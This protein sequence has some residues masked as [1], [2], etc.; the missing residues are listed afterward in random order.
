MKRAEIYRKL[1]KEILGKDLYDDCYSFFRECFTRK[2]MYKIILTRRCFSLFKIFS[3]ILKADGIENEYGMIITDNAVSL[4]M[5]EIR[6][7]LGDKNE[8]GYG[9]ASVLIID[10]IIIYGRTINELLNRIFDSVNTDSFFR[11]RVICMVKNTG[12]IIDEKYKDLI[13]SRYGASSVGWK[14]YSYKFSKLIKAADI[15][16]TSYIVSYRGSLENISGNFAE[17][18]FQK[19]YFIKNNE[20]NDLKVK[21][22][23]LCVSLK[24]GNFCGLVRVYI[25]NKI[26]SFLIAPLIILNE[27]D[28]QAADEISRQV[29]KLYCDDA[30]KT[31]ALLE[32]GEKETK[33]RMLTL[34]ASHVLLNDFAKKHGVPLTATEFSCEGLYD[35]EEIIEFN[36]GKEYSL[37]FEVIGKK[38]LVSESDLFNYKSEGIYDDTKIFENFIFNKAMQD[39]AAAKE[40]VSKRR[41]GFWTMLN[42]ESLFDEKY[43]GNIMNTLDNGIAALKGVVRGEKFRSLLY[44]GEQAFRVM[45]NVCPKIL[46]AMYQLEK[47]SYL[48]DKDS[49]SAYMGFLECREVKKRISSDIIRQL[50]EYIEVLKENGQQISD[51]TYMEA[52]DD[53]ELADLAED[54]FEKE[55]LEKVDV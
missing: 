5:E 35:N 23:V 18:C 20:L 3:V 32:R 16:N 15:S 41:E 6:S 8:R 37:E 36:F 25:Y 42:G 13:L 39:N 2:S 51:V 27:M 24:N 21:P 7:A 48:Y 10:D 52:T 14:K 47:L 17:T 28:M 19:M 4:N 22:Y 40:D 50:K 1:A 33:M 34:L 29:A 38:I 45:S 26:R 31:K 49:Y 43:A 46:P 53:D 30:E 44:S 55:F 11:L 9:S 12:S 54:F